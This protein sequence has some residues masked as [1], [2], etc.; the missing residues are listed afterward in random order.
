MKSSNPII[1]FI[2]QIRYLFTFLH[3]LHPLPSSQRFSKYCV[4]WKEMLSFL[5]EK[6]NLSMQWRNLQFVYNTRNN[7]VYRFLKSAISENSI[8]IL[9]GSSSKAC[10]VSLQQFGGI[11]AGFC[12]YNRMHWLGQSNL[13]EASSFSP[14]FWSIDWLHTPFTLCT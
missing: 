7:F 3:P 14:L 12:C 1:C 13:G 8:T 5:N 4:F 9:F 10:A 6:Y 2:L 11:F